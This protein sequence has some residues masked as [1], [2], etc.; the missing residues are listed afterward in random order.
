MVDA[1]SPETD[2]RGDEHARADAA[3][4]PSPN[5]VGA[6]GSERDS[7]YDADEVAA[8][9]DGTVDAPDRPDSPAPDAADVVSE[10]DA[11]VDA[12]DEGTFEGG[13]EDAEDAASD[14]RAPEASSADD[15]STPDSDDVGDARGE[16]DDP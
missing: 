4:A 8:E 5:E 11:P 10:E 15:S 6:G 3:D 16:A 7:G 1:T 2:A 13:A 12:L 14:Q 9:P